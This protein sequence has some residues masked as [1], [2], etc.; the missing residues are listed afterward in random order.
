MLVLE[1][2]MRLLQQR[3]TRLHLVRSQ[4]LPPE[5]SLHYKLITSWQ[6][7][8]F[9]CFDPALLLGRMSS[10]DLCGGPDKGIPNGMV[11][12]MMRAMGGKLQSQHINFLGV[13]VVLQVFQHFNPPLSG[14]DIG[15]DWQM[16]DCDLHQHAARVP[17]SCSK[18]LWSRAKQ[19]VL[20]L[21]S[22]IPGFQSMLTSLD[23]H[24]ALGVLS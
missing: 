9:L 23:S 19:N 21:N 20:S 1:V 15:K 13:D 2:H 5:E 17:A 11:R 12:R 10:C 6:Q 4:V 14:N 3:F 22:W 24:M 16:K 8:G 18:N 7:E